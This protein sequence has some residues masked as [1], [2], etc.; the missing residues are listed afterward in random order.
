MQLELSLSGDVQVKRKLLRIGDRAI[1]AKPAFE[2]IATVLMGIER[3]QFESEG[4]RS[5]GGWDELAPSTIEAK[6]D[7]RILFESGALMA[8]LS[9]DGD[10]NMTNQ[11]TDDFLLFGSKLGYAGYHQTGTSRMPQ[12]RPLE[13]RET[14]RVGITKILQTHILGDGDGFEIAQELLSRRGTA[15]KGSSSR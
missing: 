11:A 14:D 3:A 8:S 7:S 2:A 6:G 9:E 15:R 10:E 13:L 4:R 1:H 5:S 12:R